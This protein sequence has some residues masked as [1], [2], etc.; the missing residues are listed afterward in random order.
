MFGHPGGNWPAALFILGVDGTPERRHSKAC[1]PPG[2]ARLHCRMPRRR[3]CGRLAAR[4]PHTPLGWDQLPGHRL[5]RTEPAGRGD[6]PDDDGPAP[7]RGPIA[8]TPATR[9]TLC[10]SG[11]SHG[12]TR[13][14][15]LSGWRPGQIECE[16][17]VVVIGQRGIGQKVLDARNTEGGAP[18]IGTGLVTPN[19][20]L[21]PGQDGHRRAGRGD[22]S[23][24]PSRDLGDAGH[25][26]R[27]TDRVRGPRRGGLPSRGR[28]RSRT[29]PPAGPSLGG[30]P[31]TTR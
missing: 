24:V 3:Q 13:R 19:T 14:R 12:R 11:H 22:G 10:R 4:H 17:G 28:A 5:H 8:T 21:G 27:R 9:P 6:H 31:A 29:S 20:E 25:H 30:G 18:V 15:L 1:L 26:R 16:G 23:G 7:A 2:A